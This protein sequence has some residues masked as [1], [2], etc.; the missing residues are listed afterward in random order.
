MNYKLFLRQ[1]LCILVRGA[2][3]GGVGVL[4][5]NNGPFEILLF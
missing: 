5:I 1:Q 3:G 4:S 2:D